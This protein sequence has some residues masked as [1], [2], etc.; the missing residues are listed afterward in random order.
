MRARGLAYDTLRVANPG[1]I[2]CSLSPFGQSGPYSAYRASDITAV[3]MG[4]NMYPTGNPECA[5]VRCSLPVAYFHAGIETAVAIVFALWDRE[6]TGAGQVLDVSLHEAMVMPDMTMPAQFPLTGNKGRR[7]GALFRGGQAIFREI[8]P[9]RDGHVSFALRGG[10]ARI[11]GIVRLVDYM[12]ENGMAPDHLKQRNWTSYNHNV[13]SQE[14]V[15][16]IESAIGAFFRTKTMRELFDAAC[17]R[18]LMLAPANT[19]RELMTSRQLEAREFFVE[20]DHPALESRLTYPGAIAKTAPAGIGIRRPAPQ[21]GEHNA[22]VY[23][24]IGLDAD[25][26]E[27]LAAEGIV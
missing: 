4:G 15:D 26:L 7:V 12:D 22:E 2:V 14:D 16:R 27:E 9:C 5:P 3:A 11:P 20:I 17:E 19:A 18:N 21:L 24:K 23:G 10:A 8:W 6:R 25:R 1:I 13:V